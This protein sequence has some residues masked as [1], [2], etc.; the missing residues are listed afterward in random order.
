MI[1]LSRQI[2]MVEAMSTRRISVAKALA[3]KDLS[4]TVD[5]SL[6]RERV[7]MTLDNRLPF[8]FDCDFARVERIVAQV[9]E[10]VQHYSSTFLALRTE[11]V[12]ATHCIDMMRDNFLELG[13]RLSVARGDSMPPASGEAGRG[14]PQGR[15]ARHRTFPLCNLSIKAARANDTDVLRRL[16]PELTD[17]WHSVRQGCP[18]DYPCVALYVAL[19]GIGRVSEARDVVDEYVNQSRVTRNPPSPFIAS[20]AK[21]FGVPLV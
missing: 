11:D 9:R 20:L 21:E 15:H 4:E 14:T 8:Y 18:F 16:A 13:D 5:G 7:R 1:L 10:R 19:S 12:Y 2:A 6:S 3:E 17:A